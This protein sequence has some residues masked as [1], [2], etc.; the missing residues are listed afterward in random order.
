MVG[1]APLQ[2]VLEERIRQDWKWG[3]ARDLPDEVW[4][5]ILMEEVGEAAE[6]VL[7]SLVP[8]SQVD[9]GSLRTEVVQSCAVALAW[10]EALGR[11]EQRGSTG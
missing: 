4:L 9:A 8:G 6:A 1:W 10:L 5:A 11:R 3:P 2:L 7:N